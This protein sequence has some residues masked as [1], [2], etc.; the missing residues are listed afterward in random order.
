MYAVFRVLTSSTAFS[1]ARIAASGG[2][3]GEE[4]GKGDGEETHFG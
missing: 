2:K 4:R 3:A 1:V